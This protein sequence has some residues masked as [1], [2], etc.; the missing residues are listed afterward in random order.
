M[1]TFGSIEGI[2]SRS[3]AP[4]PVFFAEACR[5]AE[6]IPTYLGAQGY[7]IADSSKA[8]LNDLLNSAGAHEMQH[9]NLQTL[10]S[11]IQ[12]PITGL[13]CQDVG[14][15]DLPTAPVQS[16]V[17]AKAQDPGLPDRG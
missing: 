7:G 3:G 5:S 6:L 15:F 10:A 8:A 1:V 14:V 16:P 12:L 11:S 4:N 2:L 9:Q 17:I 13:A